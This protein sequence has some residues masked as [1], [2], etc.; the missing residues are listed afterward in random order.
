MH[1]QTFHYAGRAMATRDQSLLVVYNNESVKATR[2]IQI[3][4]LDVQP[5]SPTT[6]TPGSFA[7]ARITSL[8]GG[9]D[10]PIIKASEAN[11]D[12]SPLISLKTNA[13][14][15]SSGSKFRAHLILPVSTQGLSLMSVGNG[16]ATGNPRCDTG[17][18]FD[19]GYGASS[20]QRIVLREGEGVALI[21]NE[22]VNMPSNA[23]WYW[24]AVLQIG[25]E[26]YYTYSG[27]YA[28]PGSAS[29]AIYNGV[30]SG[31]VIEVVD[32]NVLYMGPTT[33]T[34]PLADAPYVRFVKIARYIGG[35]EVELTQRDTS[36]PIPAALKVVR[37]RFHNPMQIKMI[38]D[39]NGLGEGELLYPEQNTAAYRRIGIVRQS[40]TH[41]FSIM[42]PGLASNVFW[43]EFMVNDVQ[44]GIDFR[45][46]GDVAPLT[47][48]AGEGLAV[49][50]NNC[51][52]FCS[53]W[54]DLLVKHL[55]P[56]DANIRR[57]GSGK[58]SGA[59]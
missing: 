4:K 35:E 14:V 57:I 2:K 19:A 6:T 10:I 31:Q 40:M 54:I 46:S 41:M 25:S 58:I 16:Y 53:Y 51:T 42:A 43:S 36:I 15:V 5:F 28:T 7:L 29:F 48:N 1:D 21:P 34:S 26:T 30:G 49:V 39:L 55:P 20:T 52:P 8:S 3:V 12:I 45:G 44:H 50:V 9:S 18:L 27:I 17:G 47:L 24:T 11:A 32:M 23:S 22:S 56:I 37:N 59:L 13:D 38:T 33:I